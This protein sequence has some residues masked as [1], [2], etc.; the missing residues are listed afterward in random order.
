MIRRKPQNNY[1]KNSLFQ[2]KLSF[3]AASFFVNIPK[4]NSNFENNIKI[5]YNY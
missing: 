3:G 1:F 4:K 2:K 5:L